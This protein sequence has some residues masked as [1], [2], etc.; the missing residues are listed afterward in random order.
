MYVRPNIRLSILW[1]YAWRYLLAY[2]AW[3]VAVCSVKQWLLP[4]LGIPFLP[5]SLIGTA[6]ALYVGF[7]NTSAYDRHWEARK[8]W[9]SVINETRRLTLLLVTHLPASV[10]R[11]LALRGAAF[12]HALRLHLRRQQ[13]NAAY[14]ALLGPEDRALLKARHVPLAILKAQQLNLRAAFASESFVYAQLLEALAALND[15]LGRCERIKNTP[16][17]RQYAFFSQVFVWLFI[18]LLPFG[19]VPLFEEKH[20]LWLTV[21]FHLVISWVFMTMELVG[22]LTEN[23]FEN[24]M[25]DVPMTTLCRTIEANV[26]D[27]LGDAEVPPPLQPVDDV[28]M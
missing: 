22:H 26:K 2:A 8:I 24:S 3:S 12:A 19:L 5:V 17:P 7:K 25:V 23:P 20:Q 27:L 16:L 6:V 14:E 9:G 10:H 11:P 4:G 15:C 28:L 13:E 18:A 21:P 1:I